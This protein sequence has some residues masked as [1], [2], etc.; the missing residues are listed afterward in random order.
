M[1]LLRIWRQ[2]DSIKAAVLLIALALFL[3]GYC[4]RS[5]ASYAL[6]MQK[7]VEYICTASAGID[8]ILPQLANTDGIR[9]YSKQKTRNLEGS[10]QRIQV[11]L[12]NPSYLANCYALNETRTV[13]MNCPAFS[14]LFGDAQSPVLF[15]G[16][17][18]G[19]TYSASAICTDKLTQNEPL[20]VIAAGE[21]ELHDT[22][23]LRICVANQD[24]FSPESIGLTVMNRETLCAAEYE[25]KL[26]LLQIRFG[27]LSVILALT[28]AAAFLRIYRLTNTE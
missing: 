20:A 12:L 15:Q 9:A 22:D 17:L 16:K 1:K 7:P 18:D 6:F 10:Q 25:Q 2:Y 4:I 26:M 8:K 11:T 19:Q 23:S 28:G 5:A 27:V 14:E 21:S 24:V 3:T 13:Y